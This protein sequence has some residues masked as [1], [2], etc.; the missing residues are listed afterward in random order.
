PNAD[1][2]GIALR[3]LGALADP[4]AIPALLTAL[5]AENN[6]KFRR[7]IIDVLGTFADDDTVRA[8]LVTTLT[9]DTDAFLRRRA[10]RALARG[11]AARV[12]PDL[13]AALGDTDAE[14]R[15]EAAG[16]LGAL[17]DKSALAT[18]RAQYEQ[19]SVT[20][21]AIAKARW[22]LGDTEA[23]PLLLALL[24]DTDA[25][26]STAAISALGVTGDLRGVTPLA[27]RLAK[28]KPGD[29]W[30]LLEALLNL[31][32]AHPGAAELDPLVLAVAPQLSNE[33]ENARQQ[34]VSLLGKAARPAA[35]EALIRL[36]TDTTQPAWM[37]EWIY[38]ALANIRDP[39]VTRYLQTTLATGEAQERVYAAIALAKQD[40][41]EALAVLL[42]TVD[43]GLGAPG[44]YPA[45]LALGDIHNQRALAALL[46]AAEAPV[47]GQ[48]DVVLQ[49]LLRL[50]RDRAA[51]A[52][53]VVLAQWPL[54]T[55]SELR[56]EAVRWLGASRDPRAL[57]PLLAALKTAT[58]PDRLFL[59]AAL[60][61]LGDPRAVPPLIDLLTDPSYRVRRA[62]AQALA[63]LTGK[64]F[65]LDPARWRATL[66]PA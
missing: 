47:V 38:A 62:A 21:A 37:R 60:G 65:G 52:V 24:D 17:G 23:V 53:P 33:D 51:A 29:A 27:A 44:Y 42:D 66:P 55:D 56:K 35:A 3:G 14:V 22:Q 15:A 7:Q 54:V 64:N 10:V 4:Q 58:I 36:A 2:R 41:G 12:L 59:L 8:L 63:A 6:D 25:A 57:E 31:T 5:Q 20:R 50:P 43:Q 11:Q 45:L 30:P 48:R 34:C 26:A 9:R 32:E 28:T 16:A 61:T 19:N 40:A 13:L 39:R 1:V 18:L 46:A 49:A